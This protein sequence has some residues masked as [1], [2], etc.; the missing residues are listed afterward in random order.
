MPQYNSIALGSFFTFC[1]ALWLGTF[2]FANSKD[3]GKYASRTTYAACALLGIW[4]LG[5]ALARV[6]DSYEEALFWQRVSALG[7]APVF[8]VLLH[9][10]LSLYGSQLLRGWW[11]YL[12]VYFPALL[13]LAVFSISRFL[14][15]STQHFVKTVTGWVAMPKADFWNLFSRLYCSSFMVLSIA[16]L[17]AWVRK[18]EEPTQRGRNTW[19]A[20]SLLGVSCVSLLFDW[21]PPSQFPP[22]LVNW[23]PTTALFLTAMVFMPSWDWRKHL[24]I[25]H[26]SALPEA[27]RGEILSEAD[28]L[29]LYSFLAAMHML[30]G[31]LYPALLHFVLRRPLRV[32]TLLWGV[33]FF[34]LGAST[35]YL[36]SL[37]IPE[38]RRDFL[39]GLLLSLSA[40]FVFLHFFTLGTKSAL[41]YLPLACFV[42]PTVLLG[43]FWAFGA[44]SMT[45]VAI[46]VWLW[47][48]IPDEAFGDPRMIS[49]RSLTTLAL[50][51]FIS[52]AFYIR[53]AYFR[54]T[55][56]HQEQLLLQ[57]MIADLSTELVRMRAPSF[58]ESLKKMLRELGERCEVDCAYFFASS[59]VGIPACN[60]YWSRKRETPCNNLQLCTIENLPW[61]QGRVAKGDFFLVT[62]V[63]ALP[64]EDNEL[65]EFLKGMGVRSAALIPVKRDRRLLGLLTLGTE[66]KKRWQDH[67]RG[68]LK[69]LAN[70]LADVLER[71]GYES[72]IQR[73]AFYDN[74]TGLPNRQLFV[75]HLKKEIQLAKRLKK[76]L[77]VAFLDLDS[78]KTINDVEGHTVGDEVLR[79]VAQ[80]IVQCVRGHDV[81]AR[82][83]GDEFLLL[84][85][86]LSSVEEIPPIIERVLHTIRE[87]LRM[88]VQE[89]SV[90]ASCGIA[91]YPRDGENSEE[92]VQAAD[93]A[94]YVS[95]TMKGNRYSFYFPA[96]REDAR[97]K[98][99]LISGLYRAL[100]HGELVLYYQPQVHART[101]N[102]VGLEA[103]LRWRH[104]DLGL[105]L[106][107]VFMP[108]AEQT[109][110]IILIG[111]FVLQAACKQAVTWQRI[112]IVPLRIAVNLSFVQLRDP[113]LV[114]KVK[115]ALEEAALEANMLELEVTENAVF[116]DPERTIELLKKL[117]QL[118]V[119]IA[120]DDFGAGYSSLFRLEMLPIDRIKIDQ[121]LFQE[122]SDGYQDKAVVENVFE[123]VKSTN[124]SVI[125]EGVENDRQIDFI[126]EKGCQEVQGYYY[127]RPMPPEEV[128]ALLLE[129]GRKGS[130]TNSPGDT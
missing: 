35:Y 12:P 74:L 69:V 11:S 110:L 51:A 130:P 21:I 121:H 84:L 56:E 20:Y 93:L 28:K 47:L 80:R 36:C 53:N 108:L 88:G 78:F 44:S 99:A 107:D 27:T 17:L 82:F 115:K 10:A 52:L 86:N 59:R 19:I 33:L 1:Y 100:E 39:L 31:F 15:E 25:R 79:E 124:I 72:K 129:K 101:G 2:L 57:K 81:V 94:M 89:L 64:P 66:S 77:A 60:V 98:R 8:G 50:I 45:M 97:Q 95:K 103:L 29:S 55:E 90:T 116:R 75:E 24:V 111:E 37:R 113:H 13:S 22:G 104:P 87:P 34:A 65:Q 126:V 76:L 46:Q 62:D 73:M 23:S 49:D 96:L 114:D 127:Y 102:I 91:I 109:E 30:G 117:K 26:K 3:K 68:F 40:F 120:L 128:E 43:N 38:K 42:L 6:A 58:T 123:L 16:L 106:P 4:S 122:T 18:L 5:A 105:L 32:E 71:V 119:R 7:W 112:G 125:A 63:N 54:R 118:G 41:Y 70:V 14:V 9:W 83:G 61:F 85:G 67:H 92:L 48:E